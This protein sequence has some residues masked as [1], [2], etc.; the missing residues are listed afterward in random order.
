M[1]SYMNKGNKESN[2]R[3]SSKDK[4]NGGF[5]NMVGGGIFAMGATNYLNDSGFHANP[6][7]QILQLLDRCEDTDITHH[8]DHFK[9]FSALKH[10]DTLRETLVE[11]SRRGSFIRIYPA[12]GSDCYDAYFH[13]V[14][15]LNRYLYK[16]LFTEELTK[17]EVQKS[18]EQ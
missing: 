11:Y 7:Q 13:Q 16:M 3:Y 15:P 14:R 9:K 8:R 6:N 10:K 2:A 1:K 4:R 17:I 5:A 12:K 18:I